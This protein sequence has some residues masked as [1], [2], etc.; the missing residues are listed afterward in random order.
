MSQGR[1]SDDKRDEIV[2]MSEAGLKPNVI[3]EEV[4]LSPSTVY[5][6]LGEEGQQPV[7]E[8]AP[9]SFKNLTEE[10]VSEFIERYLDMEPIVVLLDAYRLTH[11]QMYQLLNERQITPRTRR[12]ENKVARNLALEHALMLYQETSVTIAEI[13]LET[14]VHQPVLHAAIRAREIPLRRPRRTKTE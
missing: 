9:T 8:Y 5:K 3:A 12:T 2:K 1:I 10:Q 13:V 14:G 6:V 4:D 11:I 7:K